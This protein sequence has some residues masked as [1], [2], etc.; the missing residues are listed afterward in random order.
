M[1][2]TILNALKSLKTHRHLLL[3]GA[4]LGATAAACDPKIVGDETSGNVTCKEGDTK[5]AE[6]GCN[7]CTCTDGGW[8]CTEIACEGLECEE[9]ETKP[10]EDGCNT[11]TCYDGGWACTEKGCPDTEGGSETEG[12]GTDGEPNETVGTSGPPVE[13]E[14]SSTTEPNPGVCGDGVIE[15]LES[16]DD[17]NTASGDGCSSECLIEGNSALT[18][19]D[20]AP[21]DPYEIVGAEI[22]GDTLVADIERSGG[23]TEHDYALCWDG[24]FAESDPVQIDL[25]I[26]HDAHDDLCDAWISEQL[27]FS[28]AEL[29]AA[30]QASYQQE[31]GQISVGLD[32]WNQG[33]AYVF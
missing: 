28:L 32:G 10:A 25:E 22:V 14:G 1:H 30:W 15:G 33:L 4:L 3:A 12:T 5:P 8:A 13:T 2:R 11:C 26:S 24:L 7:T 19:P 20:P 9:G 16:C 18:C 6:D 23:C 31:H 27:V 17:G 29:K 21:A